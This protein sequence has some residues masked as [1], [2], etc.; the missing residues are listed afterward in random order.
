MKLFLY[1]V[2]D[3]DN[4]INK[5]LVDP[6]EIGIR[7][8]NDVDVV[9]PEIVLRNLN[10]VNFDSFNYAYIDVLERYYFVDKLARV[11]ASDSWLYLSCDV[12]ET[13]KTEILNSSARLKRNIKTG[14]YMRVNIDNNI[15]TS[16]SIHNSDKSLPDDATENY[17]VSVMGV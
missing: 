15:N 12:L 9:R 3:G 5:T 17:I 14:D 7:L 2:A 11:N 10:G 4:V 16:V 8:N 1:N 13:Y 6:L